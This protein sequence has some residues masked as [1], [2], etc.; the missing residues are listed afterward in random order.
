MT[1]QKVTLTQFQALQKIYDHMNR[2]LFKGELGQCLINLSRKSK[3]HSFFAPKR[4]SARGSE[5]RIHEISINPQ[6]INRNPI[7][8]ISTLVHEMAH[9][10]Q[11]DHGKPSAQHHNK[12]WA[13]KMEELGLIPS[14]TGLPGGKKTGRNMTHYIEEGGAYER[15]FAAMP[16]DYIYTFIAHELNESKA[17]KAKKKAKN[18][19]KY[20]CDSCDSNVWGKPGLHIV[21]QDCGHDFCEQ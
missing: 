17:A 19:V 3:A 2:K 16:D 15:A 20:T 12:E 5:E 11:E 10:W 1:T 13:A 21:C 7:A 8:V 14:S 6:T 18:K 9:L 4:W